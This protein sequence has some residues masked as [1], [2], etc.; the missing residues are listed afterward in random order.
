MIIWDFDDQGRKMEMDGNAW[1]FPEGSTYGLYQ[2]TF[3]PSGYR[4][5]SS[6][7]RSIN[8]ILFMNITDYLP[9]TPSGLTL[10]IY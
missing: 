4:S 3:V 8:S 1:T 9:R 7:L 5:N 2:D 10:I 6:K